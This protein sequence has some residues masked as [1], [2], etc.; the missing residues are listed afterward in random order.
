MQYLVQPG[1]ACRDERGALLA[2]G[3]RTSVVPYEALCA[4]A[5]TA[6]AVPVGSV[7]YVRKFAELNGIMLP[8]SDTYPESLRWAMGRNI[9]SCSFAQVPPDSFCKPQRT[10]AFTGG[11]KGDI[12]EPVA[13]SEPVWCSERVEFSAEFRAY[14]V[15][16]RIAGYSRYGDGDDEAELN[17]D[18][19]ARVVSSYSQAP[20]GYAI[21][22]GA[23]PAGP[24]L[25][26]INDGWALG[27]YRWG[28]MKPRD[29]VQLITERWLQIVRNK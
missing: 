26:E 14:V 22:I 1:Q 21:D 16:G 24:C 18:F 29:Y 7:E 13:D 17:L 28:N 4:V 23:T 25:V 15:N 5:D 12:A 9:Y 8:D 2:D 10:K 6:E 11:I 19:L 27:Y 20:V 3:C